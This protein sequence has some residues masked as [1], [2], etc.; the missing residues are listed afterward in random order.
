MDLY[1]V[2]EQVSV[3]SAKVLLLVNYRSEYR[4]EW[5]KW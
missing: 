2:L 5:A 4:H 3:A 1:E